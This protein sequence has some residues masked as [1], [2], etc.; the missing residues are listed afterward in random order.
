MFTGLVETTARIAA[1]ERGG[2]RGKLALGGLSLAAPALSLG[3][4]ISVSGVCLT[5]TRV[6]ADG[7]EADVSAET[8]AVTT[9]EYWRVGQFTNIEVDVLAR[10]V[11]RQLDFAGKD[12]D[13]RLADKLKEGGFLS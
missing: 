6:T 10:Y 11:G 5:V 9:L 3:E 8:L 13:L 4:S 2:Q 12:P 7:F 1:F